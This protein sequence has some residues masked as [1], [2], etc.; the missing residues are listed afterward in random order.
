MLSLL[1]YPSYYRVLGFPIPTARDK[2]FADLENEEFIVRNDAGGW[3]ITNLGALMIAVD[4]TEFRQL[5]KRAVRVIQY[6]GDGRLDGIQ[7]RAFSKGRRFFRRSPHA[8]ASKRAVL[9]YVT[10]LHVAHAL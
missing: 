5:A 2:I 3:G 8:V 7:E 1:D 9:V 4:L 6:R 10:N